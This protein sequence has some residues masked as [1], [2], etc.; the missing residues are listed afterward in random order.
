M[1]GIWGRRHD[2]VMAVGMEAK[3]HLG[4]GWFFEAQAL[5]ADRHAPVAADL[6]GGAHAPDRIRASLSAA[7]VFSSGLAPLVVLEDEPEPVEAN[8]LL[9]DSLAG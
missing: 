9:G 2:G 4:L 8:P 7:P 6:D 3:D 1:L 5:G